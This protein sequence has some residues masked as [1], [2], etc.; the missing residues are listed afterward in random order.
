[1]LLAS[2]QYMQYMISADASSTGKSTSI[3][4]STPVSGY[5]ST[6]QGYGRIQIDQTL[7]FGPSNLNPISLFVIGDTDTA[8]SSY[9]QFTAGGQSDVYTFS[10]AATNIPSNV[11]IA[12]VW[13]DP[14]SQVGTVPTM[15]N[16]LNVQVTGGA[17]TYTPYSNLGKLMLFIFIHC[18][19]NTYLLFIYTL[20]LI[21]YA[22][23]YSVLYCYT[24]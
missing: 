5:P 6:E 23:N 9:K 11:R 2:A 14:P 1:M 21:V 3:T 13:T 20:L 17:Q 16:V 24:Y 10:T 8:S 18:T 22:I 7:N 4:K 19:Y 15:I 12:L